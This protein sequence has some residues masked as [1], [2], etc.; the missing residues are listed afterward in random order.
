MSLMTDRIK[1]LCSLR[2]MSTSKLERS[3]GGSNGVIRL[4]FER[5]S[6]PKIDTLMAV[7]KALDTTVA[8]L[9]G[10]TDNPARGIL[11]VENTQHI[12]DYLLPL[13]QDECQWIATKR[14]VEKHSAYP[15]DEEELENGINAILDNGI[16]V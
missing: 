5:N 13:T 7:A 9:I 14:F 8:Y 4:W 6:Q 15:M 2:N 3:I 10:E 1:E 16:Q 12:W 11:E